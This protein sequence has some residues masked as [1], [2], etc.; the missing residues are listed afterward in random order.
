MADMPSTPDLTTLPVDQQSRWR[1]GERPPVEA[2]LAKQPPLSGDAEA[3]LELILH[4]VL[5]RRE[6]SEAPALAEYQQRFPHLAGPLAVQFQVEDALEGPS[7][8]PAPT[9]V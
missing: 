3:V 9:V 4:E 1:R 5:L 6:R 7:S 8:P 2:Y